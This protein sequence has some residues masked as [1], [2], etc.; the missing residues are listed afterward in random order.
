MTTPPPY[1]YQTVEEKQWA[2]VAHFGGAVGCLFSA[3]F[4][5]LA[6]LVVY[7]AKGQTSQTVRAHS[8][9]AFNFQLPVSA[10]GL[11][12]S[13]L[14]A[15]A[16]H[17]YFPGGLLLTVIGLFG[18]VFGVIAG[19]RANEGRLYRYPLPWVILR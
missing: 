16:F 12:V 1:G 5:F 6:P 13:L 7:I 14:E 19:L 8:M 10:A 4:G 17:W 9:A 3:S 15:C 18:A 2:L 11:L